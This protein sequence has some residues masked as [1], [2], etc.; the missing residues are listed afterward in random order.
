M[1][2][3]LVQPKKE[4]PRVSYT[5]L[6]ETYDKTKGCETDVL[7]K[8]ALEQAAGSTRVLW[9]A[10]SKVETSTIS[11]VFV[12]PIPEPFVRAFLGGPNKQKVSGFTN[13]NDEFVSLIQT[14]PKLQAKLA[15]MA[16]LCW[17]GSYEETSIASKQLTWLLVQL[18][19]GLFSDAKVPIDTVFTFV[20]I[21]FPITRKVFESL[22]FHE[23]NP[24]IRGL[25]YTNPYGTF[26]YVNS[27]L[28]IIPTESTRLQYD[29]ASGRAARYQQELT[30]LRAENRRLQDQLQS[31]ITKQQHANC[32]R[33]L[34][35]CDAR[36]KKLESEASQLLEQ[37]T[38][39]TRLLQNRLK[40]I[41][42]DRA[43]Y[44]VQY[45]TCIHEKEELIKRQQ[46]LQEQVNRQKRELDKL[47][48]L[49]KKA[50]QF[51]IIGQNQTQLEELQKK[52]AQYDVVLKVKDRE[53]QELNEIIK[54]QSED[55]KEK[56]RLEYALKQCQEQQRQISFTRAQGTVSKQLQ[57]TEQ[58]LRAELNELTRKHE[59]DQKILK[60]CQEQNGKM[61]AIEQKISECKRNLQQKEEQ[62]TKLNGQ[63]ESLQ[64]EKPQ[65]ITMQQFDKYKNE[66]IRLRGELDTLRTQLQILEQVKKELKECKTQ[67][68]T[69][70]A[71]KPD[72]LPN[73][74]RA[75]EFKLIELTKRH[76][77]NQQQL[78]ATTAK[79]EELQKVIQQI[80]TERDQL[81]SQTQAQYK[82]QIKDMHQKEATKIT[83]LNR[84]LDEQTR[85]S[86]RLER[87]MR[88][89][90]S[91]QQ[92]L[93]R[94]NQ[95]LAE[96]IQHL[97]KELASRQDVKK[98]YDAL[99]Q[100]HNG[101]FGEYTKV[102]QEMDRM[103]KQTQLEGQDVQKLKADLQRK[104]TSLDDCNRDVQKLKDD[105]RQLQQNQ[106]N[107]SKRDRE[108]SVKEFEKLKGDLLK[109]EQRAQQLAEQVNKLKAQYEQKLSEQQL[110]YRTQL[111]GEQNKLV[112]HTRVLNEK[113]LGKDATIADLKRKLDDLLR[114]NIIDEK[115]VRQID[116][117]KRELESAKRDKLATY[118]RLQETISQL[119][120]CT[121]KFVK[122]QQSAETKLQ[123]EI[124]KRERIIDELQKNMSRKESELQQAKS[125]QERVQKLTREI[126][127]LRQQQT[128]AN[129]EKD[130]KHVTSKR[131]DDGLREKE[132][133]IAILQEQLKAKRDLEVELKQLRDQFNAF[134]N[135]SHEQK[136]A[137]LETI[138]MK[139]AELQ[140]AKNEIDILHNKQRQ[141]QQQQ[142]ERPNTDTKHVGKGKDNDELVR[143]RDALKQ[144][145]QELAILNEELKARSELKNRPP[146]G[147]ALDV[148]LVEKE[149]NEL[150]QQ[151]SKCEQ[152]LRDA[153]AKFDATTK[154]NQTV[155][156]QTTTKMQQE[157]QKSANT[158]NAKIQ[159]LKQQIT[160]LTQ[161]RELTRHT[162]KKELDAKIAITNQQLS[163]LATEKLDLEQ[164]LARK[165]DEYTKL[166][167]EL[168]IARRR[169]PP[170]PPSSPPQPVSPPPPL[171]VPPPPDCSDCEQELARLKREMAQLKNEKR[172]LEQEMMGRSKSD[173]ALGVLR[174]KLVDIEREK[175]EL[176]KEIER[177]KD[178]IPKLR[179]C[180]Q[181][182]LE[183]KAQ[184]DEQHKAHEFA[185]RV[186]ES[187]RDDLRKQLSETTSP[188]SSPL[189]PP[190]PSTTSS[191]SLEFEALRQKC[192]AALKEQAAY[193]ELKREHALLLSVIQR[194]ETRTRTTTTRTETNQEMETMKTNLS[195][196][197]EGEVKEAVSKLVHIIEQRGQKAAEEAQ[198][199]RKTMEE[200]QSVTFVEYVSG[201]QRL[202]RATIPRRRVS[203]ETREVLQRLIRVMAT[204]SSSVIMD[205]CK[206][207]EYLSALHLD[208]ED[209][210]QLGQ[211]ETKEDAEA[212]TAAIECI[213]TQLLKSA[214]SIA[215]QASIDTGYKF[216]RLRPIHLK[217]A[218]NDSPRLKQLFKSIP[219]KFCTNV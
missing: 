81:L 191:S 143:I 16:V 171:P 211:I 147:P 165:T 148:T 52:I 184:M 183:L 185:K 128:R 78:R 21:Q 213:L 17:N 102:K 77:A 173:A 202:F 109:S 26:L 137:L 50:L 22:G 54:L 144:K 149:L 154:R 7:L 194:F 121:D 118:K 49:Q 129:D 15:F 203:M 9:K 30:E 170:P 142:H 8:T 186:L 91:E 41:E 90:E 36:I 187:E 28:L 127:I 177:M 38:D 219:Y 74:L 95:K 27:D 6:Q 107:Q 215:K 31:G 212:L 134:Q 180:Q 53:I 4:R 120:E 111:E 103:Q 132:R 37:D 198:E 62:I 1:T 82:T 64:T 35:D 207:E 59:E 66:N 57:A 176:R 94:E 47:P 201:L 3:V 146:G 60:L 79:Q 12:T 208:V 189:P 138:Q 145:E 140:Q 14:D 76:E 2:S 197:R 18:L 10:G 114:K 44:K 104:M 92:G 190:L 84:Q 40:N 25:S 131:E 42:K 11:V 166:Q 188:S 174:V 89:L 67:T 160:R 156:E 172:A 86:Q 122:M 195:S 135:E 167:Q 130:T 181:E 164:Q 61:L 48:D 112:T 63:I 214:V 182:L 141:Q 133:E 200:E 98:Q 23:L 73:E 155:F 206:E 158:L 162:H 56:K 218:K 105:I 80:R 209:V 29:L 55:V 24:I 116:E 96:T 20:P 58:K 196:M 93:K 169:P 46:S 157:F 151:K 126:E 69:T 168:Q 19:S 178:A 85:K 45:D 123:I 193:Y 34:K 88:D 124:R 13:M 119:N 101:L 100:Q 179:N 199:D 115:N 70:N 163:T 192:E 43:F 150:R 68:S 217:L 5:A 205:Y 72:K 33:D 87:D 39:Q 136:A 204:S 75:C 99:V 139:E 83:E 106:Q 117:L 125:C 159:E 153:Q 108:T 97:T 71:G 175:T 32:I 51:E 110:I 161:E 152:E 210:A 113:L 216:V 65:S